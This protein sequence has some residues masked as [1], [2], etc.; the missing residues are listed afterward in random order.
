MPPYVPGELPTEVLLIIF[1]QLLVADL[2][3]CSKVCKRWQII[4]QDDCLWVDLYKLEWP[5]ES[6]PDMCTEATCI[7][8][9]FIDNKLKE[10]SISSQRHRELEV[11][12]LNDMRY[13]YN[14]EIK[15]QMI[16]DIPDAIQSLHLQSLSVIYT[17]LR[18]FP[19]VIT[20][21]SETLRELNMGY[22]ALKQLPPEIGRLKNLTKLC[23]NN[24]QL[25]DL[26]PEIGDL[27]K[28]QILDIFFNK[29]QHLPPEIGHLTRLETLSIQ[30]NQLLSLPPELGKC[31]HLQVVDLSNNLLTELPSEI[32]NL[33]NLRILALGSNRL[34]KLDG[35]AWEKLTCL[36][37]LNVYNNQLKTIPPE[38]ANLTNLTELFLHSNDLIIHRL[39][40]GVAQKAH[41]YFPLVLLEDG[42]TLHSF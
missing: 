6:S 12:L 39:V 22:N 23:L 25:D 14:L 37:T 17:K 3:A 32:D 8:V 29:L 31:N 28:L 16:R 36:H 13:V 15:S 30:S 19:I 21:L 4:S 38:I 7:R 9:K 11:A 40:E 41:K 27:G 10:L 34:Q 1:R 18:T 42:D 5:W 2:V 33:Q 20:Q 24:N 26:P 35:V